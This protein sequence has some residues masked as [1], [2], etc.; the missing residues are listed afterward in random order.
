MPRVPTVFSVE[1]SDEHMVTT[2]ATT[3][4][5]KDNFEDLQ[6]AIRKLKSNDEKTS[7]VASGETETYTTL[8]ELLHM[9]LK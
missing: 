1:Q 5:P 4:K 3:F 7:K 8:G 6:E 2:I 9:H